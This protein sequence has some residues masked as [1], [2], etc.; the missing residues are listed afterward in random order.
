[1]LFIK[2]K[3]LFLVFA[4]FLLIFIPLVFKPATISSL[5]NI[6]MTFLFLLLEVALYVIYSRIGNWD[7]P[8]GSLMT[9]AL[10][11]AL[12]RALICLVS[13][14]LIFM[15]PLSFE[16]E[17]IPF[18]L[19]WLGNPVSFLLQIIIICLMMP[20]LFIEFAP[21]LLGVELTHKVFPQFEE[22]S[23]NYGQT[24]S[25]SKPATQASLSNLFNVYT[26]DELEAQL[27]KTIGLEGFI[28][29]SEENLIMWKYLNIEIDSERLVVD[30]GF[31][32]KRMKDLT[33]A[34]ELAHT[35]KI[36]VETKDHFVV[37]GYVDSV[38]GYI[39]IFNTTTAVDEI[40]QRLN[41][42]GN[43]ISVL[44]K[45]RY[46]TLLATRTKGKANG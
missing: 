44:L 35:R 15:A 6:S 45:T 28:V 39:L 5:D 2:G 22:T 20:H 16:V 33:P 32:S 37:N 13:S 9:S 43:S 46:Q 18:I 30:L 11:L 24:Q 40:Y 41:V 27:G 19:I 14:L 31:L 23:R 26:F 3:K 4:S 25:I 21:G 12:F 34:L 7:V 38:F 10:I 17:T 36:I 29:Y 8:F 42:I 1:M